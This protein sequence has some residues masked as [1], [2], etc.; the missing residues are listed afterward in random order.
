VKKSSASPASSSLP[1]WRG[2]A[3]LSLAIILGLLLGIRKVMSESK[4]TPT[5]VVTPPTSTPLSA[6]TAAKPQ[7]PY[8]A[9]G[10]YMAENNRLADLG[11][12]EAQFAEFLAGMRA[13]Y[14]GRG[15]PLDDDAK[16]LRDEISRK[17]QSM[18]AVEQPDPVEDYFRMLREK[19]GAVRTESGLHY[20][21]TEEGTGPHPKKGDVIVLS[22]SVRQPDGVE[23][24]ELSRARVRVAVGDLL[25][26]LAE[27]VQ[28][29]A[30]GG[31]A[32]VFVP[33]NLSFSEADWPQQVP[34]GMPLAFFVELHEIVEPSALN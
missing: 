8:A 21:I 16:K 22:F 18:L 28:L 5:A 1:F 4:P 11:W 20:R 30:V 10:S 9:L 34:K 19:E 12:S 33:A 32:L 24:P 15:L 23:R 13:S 26:G 25:P 31:K 7:G 6:T 2:L 14:E 29:L 27:G 17:V 3:I